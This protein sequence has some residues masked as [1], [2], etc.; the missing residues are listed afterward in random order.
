LGTAST[1]MVSSSCEIGR[2]EV[3][4][5]KCSPVVKGLC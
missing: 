2:D 4:T 1:D 5:K 3:Y